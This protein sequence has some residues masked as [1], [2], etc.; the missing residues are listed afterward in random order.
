M[1]VAASASTRVSLA[2]ALAKRAGRGV[3]LDG[4]GSRASI[5]SRRAD[6]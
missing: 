2:E 5:A 1:P 3:F 6:G 4:A